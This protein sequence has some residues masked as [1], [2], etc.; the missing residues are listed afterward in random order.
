MTLSTLTAPIR[1]ALF[2]VACSLAPAPASAAGASSTDA[3]ARAAKEMPP[4]KEAASAKE[5]PPEG[6]KAASTAKETGTAANQGRSSTKE[7]AAGNKTKR[8]RAPVAT[9]KISYYGRRLAGRK[10]ASGERYDPSALTMAHRTLPFGTRVRVTN[11]RNGRNAVV[12][13]NDRGPWRHNRAA[14]VSLAAARKLGMLKQGVITARLE[15]ISRPRT[16]GRHAQEKKAHDIHAHGRQAD[17][18]AR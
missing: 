15:V 2:L 5:A 8:A 12:R 7:P 16:S 11:V 17:L 6:K 13:V 18:P 1:A 9:R 3:T 4:A 14:D 10:T